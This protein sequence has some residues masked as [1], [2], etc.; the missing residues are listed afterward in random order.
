M[1]ECLRLGAEANL[2]RLLAEDLDDQLTVQGFKGK[3][4]LGGYGWNLPPKLT[5]ELGTSKQ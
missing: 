3:V 5:G 1:C 4:R 2:V